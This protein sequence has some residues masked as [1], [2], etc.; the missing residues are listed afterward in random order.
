M[1]VFLVLAVTMSMAFGGECPDFTSEQD[2]LVH[3]AYAEGSQYDL[4]YTLAALLWKEAFI[5]EHVIR[6]NSKDGEYGSFG[7]T[8]VQLTTAMGLVGENNSW[9]ARAELIPL[10]VGDDLYA[11]RLGLD[12]LLKHRGLGYRGMIARYNG[13]GAAAQEYAGDV[14]DRVRLLER[15][16]MFSY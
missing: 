6:A 1:R 12:Y 4:G 5:G 7:V 13:R 9:K 11:I 16:G 8:Q 2:R 3:L 14:I 15:C 10:L